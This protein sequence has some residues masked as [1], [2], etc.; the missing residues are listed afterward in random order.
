MDL[1]V[2]MTLATILM[3]IG[4]P[5]LRE[6]RMNQQIK[7]A[8][9]LLY[10]DLKLARNDAISLNSW[11]IACP[12]NSITGCAGHSQWHQGWLVFADLNDDRQWQNE[13]P[14]LREA[15]KLDLLSVVSPDSRNHIRFFPGGTAPGSN[16]SIVFCDQRGFEKGRKIVLSNSGRMRQSTLGS[17]DEPRCPLP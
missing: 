17:S 13:E 10:S 4:I 14:L 1:L 12:G 16:T 7:S 2:T 11:T 5:G 9:S 3:M 8:I 15:I 6:Y